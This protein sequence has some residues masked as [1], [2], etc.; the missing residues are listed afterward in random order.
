MSALLLLR[1]IAAACLLTVPD[2]LGVQGATNDLVAHARQVADAA[3]PD[4]HDRVL[5]EVVP[6]ARDVGRDFDL[7]REP[8]PSHL[9]QGGVR[10]L[11]RGRIDA[12]AHPAALRAAVQRRSLGLGYLVLPALADE[13]L[14]R[15]QRVSIFLLL[16][17]LLL[18]TCPAPR[19][20][21]GRR[22][23]FP[24]RDQPARTDWGGLSLRPPR[25]GVSPLS[26]RTG[27]RDAART[28]GGSRS[29]PAHAAGCPMVW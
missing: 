3:A 20:L 12:G 17:L 19:G 9:P 25:S 23:G 13:L 1:A 6:D 29:R 22:P 16:G 11:G 10:L 2:A 15:G 8:D 28:R 7:A 26:R 24:G 14:D 27:P 4:Q 21:G 18:S 5:L